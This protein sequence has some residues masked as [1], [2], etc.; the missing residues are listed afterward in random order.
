MKYYH[1]IN[2]RIFDTNENRLNLVQDL[3]N[4][5]ACNGIIANSKLFLDFIEN[6]GLVKWVSSN[7]ENED[8]ERKY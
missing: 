5:L 6:R 3:L 7:R 1:I 2:D 8:P 4:N